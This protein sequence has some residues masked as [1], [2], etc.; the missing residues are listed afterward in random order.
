MV[1]NAELM[2]VGPD[3]VVVT[4]V[5]EAGVEVQTRVGEA[6]VVTTGPFHS[7]RVTGLDPDT[8]FDL[9]VEGAEPGEYLPTRVRTLAQPPG[10][11]V[12]TIATAND[13]H[14][15]EVE[16]GRLGDSDI[17]PILSV[18][19]GEPPYPETMNRAVIGEMIDLDPDAV[20][21]KGDLTDSG[22]PEQYAAFLAAYGVLGD[23]MYHVRGNHDAFVDPTMALEDAPYA[24]ELDGVT[25]AVLDTVA[26]G[27]DGGQLTADQRQWLDDL[28][29]ESTVPILAFGHHYVSNVSRVGETSSSFGI[30]HADSAALL[31]VF[32]RRDAIVG[33]FAGH[34]HRN[35]L[36]RF[37]PA[38]RV[39]CCEIACTKEYPGAWAEYRIH[40]GGYSQVV[41]RVTAP[42]AF[43][44]AERTRVIYAGLYRDYALG[45]LDWR[46]FTQRF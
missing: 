38:T 20:V 1:E 30:N 33:Y 28:A 40:E 45:P 8:E 2:T 6:E 44:W 35:R 4:F 43:D 19:P 11:L 3:E 31:E 21:V 27:D 24:V 25:L 18:G 29:A 9:S 39:P 36:R 7:A 5:T 46:C 17:G 32:A 13:V 10:R 34:T 16:C 22:L 23:R 26:P 14:F 12:A 41:R 42:D 15:G 37:E